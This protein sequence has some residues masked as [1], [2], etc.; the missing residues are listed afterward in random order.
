MRICAKIKRRDVKG[1]TV[2]RYALAHV[3]PRRGTI[4][5][6]LHRRVGVITGRCSL[7]A[8][9]VAHLC[10]IDGTAENYCAKTDNVVVV[11]SVSIVRSMSIVSMTPAA[12]VVISN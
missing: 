5:I 11:D 3:L 2:A 10:C 1:W 6:E 8:S 9:N 12:L 4:V 7:R